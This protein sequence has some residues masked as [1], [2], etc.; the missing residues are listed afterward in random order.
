MYDQNP[1]WKDRQLLSQDPD[2]KKWS[3][4][5]VKWM[6]DLLEQLRLEPFSLTFIFGPRQVGK[7]T[8]VKLAIE[9]LLQ[10]KNPKAIFYYRCDRLSDYKELDQVLRAYLDLKKAEGIETAYIFLDEITFPKEWYRSIKYRIDT[11]EL[12]KDVLVLTGSW[13]LY[14]RRETE[15]FPGRRG[16]GQD[17]TF[18]PL[19]FREFLR[20][21]NPKLY[22]NLGELNSL[23]PAQ[24]WESCLRM[25]PW[26]DELN[27]AFLAY[28]RCG[29][30]PLAVKSL[31]KEGEVSREAKDAFLSSFLSDLAKLRRSEG[32][33]KRVLKAVIEKLP[34]PVSLNAVATEFEIGSHKTV[35]YFL[36]LFEKMFVAKNLHFLDPAKLLEVYRKERKVHLTDPLLYAVFSEWCMTRLPPEPA[37]VESVTA[38]HLARKYRVGYWRDGTEID[39]V[40]PEEGLGLEIKWGERA[41]VRK[42]KVGKIRETVTLTKNEFRREPPAVPVSSFLA[43]LRL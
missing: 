22:K 9:R 20:V 16:H 34:S 19:S 24:I 21:A 41:E 11:G 35:F 2:F 30:F 26:L 6:P 43:S 31:L 10:A 3:E 8:L 32:L 28:I 29:G 36:E 23:R 5:E 7:T 33:A 4:S 27:E 37:L 15:T 17:I 39:V 25:A 40:L 18:H 1:W 38:T 42:K 14:L 12:A 13:S